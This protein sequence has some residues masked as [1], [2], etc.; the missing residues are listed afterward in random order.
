MPGGISGGELARTALKRW[1]HLKVLLTS[2]FPESRI[3]DDRTPDN[4]RL[5]SKPYRRED[6][7]NT[8]REILG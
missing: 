4:I 3:G 1:P 5:L 8:V 6:L 2:G 7:A